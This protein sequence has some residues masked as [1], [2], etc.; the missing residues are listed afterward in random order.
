MDLFFPVFCVGCQ[1][2]GKYL[3]KRCSEFLGEASLIC[4]V[5]E[6]SSFTGERH[7]SCSTLYGL[8]GL[9]AVWEYEGVIKQLLLRIKYGGIGH[10]TQETME[11]AFLAIAQDTAR[12][13]QFLSFLLEKETVLTFVPMWKRKERKRGYN[14][15]LLIAQA[16]GTIISSSTDSSTGSSTSFSCAKTPQ[17]FLQKTKD[18]KSQTELA[19]IERLSNVKD[20]FAIV[21]ESSNSEFPLRFTPTLSS[22]VVLV[23]DVWTTGATMKECCK[24]LKKAGVEKVWGFVLA[25]TV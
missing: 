12:F 1:R 17:Q 2:E 13:S 16:L 18:T 11:L 24:V 22:S 7:V 9:V 19:R 25:R 15:A 10:A 5:C 21:Q 23:D 3:C 8:D 20:S 4:P 14:Q 6:E